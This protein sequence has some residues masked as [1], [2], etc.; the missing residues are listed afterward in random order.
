MGRL[1]NKTALITGGASGIGRA[2]CLGFAREGADVCVADINSSGA[3]ACASEIRK[4]GR[5]S[6]YL[7]VDVTKYKDL[8]NMVAKTI[9][10]FGRIDILVNDA[11]I[12][13]ARPALEVTEDD[14]DSTYNI[15]VKGL[16]FATQLVL[17]HMLRE[18]K[19]KIINIASSWGII[20]VKDA[21]T[22]C[23]SKAAVINLTRA[24]A[25]ELAPRKININAIGP[26]MVVTP[27]TKPILE[28]SP[29]MAREWIRNIP[30]GRPAQP[31]EIVGAAV[32]LASDESSFVTGQ[33]LM[34]DGGLTSQ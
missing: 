31:E 23:S 17:P 2:I 30:L 5:K 7:K 11:G 13:I 19:G 20:G 26:A 15:N 33:T 10:T 32:Y 28:D 6:M 21:T 8:E 12:A 34:V 14:W 4:I 16:F 27:L 25:V 3:K 22:Y 1:E 9:D 24:L 29:E 18:G